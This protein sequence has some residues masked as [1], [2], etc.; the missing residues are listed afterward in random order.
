MKKNYYVVDEDEIK[1][2]KALLD[3]DS[4]EWHYMFESEDGIKHKDPVACSRCKMVKYYNELTDDERIRTGKSYKEQNIFE[5]EEDAKVR[6]R[7]VIKEKSSKI[8]K[9]INKLEKEREKLINML[10]NV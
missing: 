9:D 7:V 1:I 2:K 4:N 8:K 10:F 6:L 3:L 5:N